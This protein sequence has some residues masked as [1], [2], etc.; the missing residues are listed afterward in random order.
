MMAL[1]FEGGVS[2][3][4]VG[5]RKHRGLE[6]PIFTT[7]PGWLTSNLA[8]K[9]YRHVWVDIRDHI[10]IQT[11]TGLGDQSWSWGHRWGL[12]SNLGK[13][14]VQSNGA[15]GVRDKKT[16]WLDADPGPDKAGTYITCWD[17]EPPKG[18]YL[19]TLTC[20]VRWVKDR[21]RRW[22]VVT[23]EVTVFTNHLGV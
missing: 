9:T 13:I 5:I 17:V 20:W 11:Q 10:W 12:E 1:S 7:S 16:D 19:A 6:V 22:E 15:N 4:R 21:I 23:W 3:Q 14:R 2:H 18:N 8:T